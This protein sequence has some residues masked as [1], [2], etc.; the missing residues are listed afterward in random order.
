[1]HVTERKVKLP[2]RWLK[3]FGEVQALYSAMRQVAEL[4][5]VHAARF[6]SALPRTARGRWAVQANQALT[7]AATPSRGAACIAGVS[8]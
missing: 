7:M 6:L 3:G 8:G 5:R 4:D 1:M 2:P